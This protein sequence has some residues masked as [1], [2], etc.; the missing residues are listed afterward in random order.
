MSPSLN[1]L[2][3]AGSSSGM[4][5][6]EKSG[7]NLR[8]DLTVSSI[9]VRFLSPRK[10][11]FSSPRRSRSVIVYWVTTESSLSASGT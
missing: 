5:S 2:N 7:L 8:T 6:I 3:V 4:F 10:S 1:I 11:I 9:T